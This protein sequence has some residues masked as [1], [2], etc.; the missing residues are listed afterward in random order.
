MND[1]D[2]WEDF[3][4]SVRA[5]Q[6]DDDDETRPITPNQSIVDSMWHKI[7]LLMI[8]ILEVGQSSNFEKKNAFCL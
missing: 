4:K 7:N 5:A 1:R 3:G 2:G 8:I 6:H